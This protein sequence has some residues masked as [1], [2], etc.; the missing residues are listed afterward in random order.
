MTDERGLDLEPSDLEAFGRA[1]CARSAGMAD[2]AAEPERAGGTGNR[3]A[4]CASRACATGDPRYESRGPA[5]RGVRRSRAPGCGPCEMGQQQ[6]DAPPPAAHQWPPAAGSRPGVA[7]SGARS[8]LPRTSTQ[9]C[10][11]RSGL[12]PALGRQATRESPERALTSGLLPED[13]RLKLPAAL[14][15]SGNA[16]PRSARHAIEPSDPECQMGRRDA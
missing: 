8:L 4:G 13:P 1:R 6:V 11:R 10:C 7:G 5:R 12:S 14:P 16:S 3:P 2:P 9:P 15:P